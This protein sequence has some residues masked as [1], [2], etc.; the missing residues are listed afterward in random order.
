MYH[1]IPL[2]LIL[3][4]NIQLIYVMIELH[5]KINFVPP[6]VLDA[7][8][9][10]STHFFNIPIYHSVVGTAEIEKDFPVFLVFLSIF[11]DTRSQSGS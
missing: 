10:A 6:H 2:A 3:F 7:F 8:Q 9:L 4:I 1:C 11:M 5:I